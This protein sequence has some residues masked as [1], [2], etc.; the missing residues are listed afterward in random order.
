[1]ALVLSWIHL[2]HDKSISGDSQFYGCEF[3][4]TYFSILVL[5][6]GL[7]NASASQDFSWMCSFSLVA[8][9]PLSVSWQPSYSCAFVS[10]EAS[11]TYGPSRH[12]TSGCQEKQTPVP[13]PFLGPGQSV[14][15]HGIW[16]LCIFWT[17]A[18]LFNL[19]VS[20]SFIP[21]RCAEFHDILGEVM[22][23]HLIAHVPPFSLM[24]HQIFFAIFIALKFKD[25]RSFLACWL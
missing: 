17:T 2:V 1:M 22:L 3:S 20:P 13:R 9:R 24:C 19:R 7:T 23:L 6:R 8:F 25:V 16:S 4:A 15:I 21:G 18:S 10:F 5:E 14:V 11:C 12:S